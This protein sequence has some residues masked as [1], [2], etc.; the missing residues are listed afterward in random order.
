MATLDEIYEQADFVVTALPATP[1]TK[2]MINA[3]VFRKMKKSAV[4]VNIGRGALVDERAL[5]E[6][7]TNEEIAGAGVD[8][9]EKE[10]I[11]AENPLLHL[12]NAFVTPH[13][14]MISKEAMDNVALKAAEDIVR[15]LEGERAVFQV[16]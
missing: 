12:P 10:P 2:H 6:A 8:V 9:V 3:S 13:V 11:T 5:V 15:V 16:N 1:E 14:A 7:L 4:L